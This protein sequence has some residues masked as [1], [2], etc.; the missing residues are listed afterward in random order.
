MSLYTVYIYVYILNSPKFTPN[1]TWYITCCDTYHHFNS[2]E[3][4]FLYFLLLIHKT[5]FFFFTWFF[6]LFIGFTLS[7]ITSAFLE[8][9]SHNVICP[10]LSPAVRPA[11]LCMLTAY[12]QMLHLVSCIWANAARDM[13]TTWD[14]CIMSPLLWYPWTVLKLNVPLIKTALL[15][16]LVLR[17]TIRAPLN[18]DKNIYLYPISDIN[19]V[20]SCV[21]V[22]LVSWCQ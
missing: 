18:L 14:G 5:F 22:F 8:L 11:S 1:G 4:V 12:C 10:H 20:T 13:I 6:Y 2:L 17:S 3:N 15:C 7:K 9:L 19:A 16:F 21:A